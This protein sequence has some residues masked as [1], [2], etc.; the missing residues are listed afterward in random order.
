MFAF[1]KINVREIFGHN[2]ITKINVHENYQKQENFGRK[3]F[4]KIFKNRDLFLQN[5]AIFMFLENFF[6][7]QPIIEKFLDFGGFNYRR[8]VW[9]LMYSQ[10]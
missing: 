7:F 3:T 5:K 9:K 4:S 8:N 6:C 10:K 1:A 2:R